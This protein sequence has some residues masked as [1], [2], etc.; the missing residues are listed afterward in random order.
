MSQGKLKI[1][2]LQRGNDPYTNERIKFFLSKGHKIFSIS[3][4]RENEKSKIEGVTYLTF[5]KL[6]IDKIPLIKRVSHYF[7]L[8]KILLSIKPDIF[9][10]VSAL[11]LFYLNYKLPIK[12]VIENQGSD[13]ILTPRKNR[14]LVPFYKTYY[15]Q[16]EGVIQ[17]SELLY[18][19]S[20]EY[21]ALDNKELNQVIEIGIDFSIFNPEVEK[22]I[23]RNKYH[24][25]GKRIILHTRGNEPLYNLDI[26]LLSLANVIKRIPDI[27]LILTTSFEKLSF[28]NQRIIKINGLFPNIV[29]VGFQDRISEMKYFYAD[30]DLVI[31]VP[32]S[33]SSPFSVYEG[34]ACKTPVIVSDLPWLYSKFIPGKHLLTVPVRD[35][36][37]L[38]DS[39]INYFATKLKIVDIDL[40]YKVVFEKINLKKE[41]GRLEEM[42]YKILNTKSA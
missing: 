21:G 4:F 13:L 29:F 28:R 39:I 25:S 37:A 10:V 14:F 18:E 27:V 32:S 20:I 23:V 41:N 5:R 8:R 3:F 16:V 9:H 2:F 31:S 7:E 6:F 12:K 33:D 26:I 36:E 38:A 40:A 15:K 17:D 1:A 30:A 35:S 22:N 24:L 42:Y 19:K 11:N 34:M